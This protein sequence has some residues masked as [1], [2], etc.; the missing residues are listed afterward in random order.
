M[1]H[2]LRAPLLQAMG[3]ALLHGQAPTAAV[4]GNQPPPS[5]TSWRTRFELGPGAV[6]NFSLYGRPELDR[7]GFRISPDG[8]ISYLEA[9]NIKVAGLSLD[10][11]RLAIEKGLSTSF[12][13]P[14]VIITPQE[15]G[16]KRYTILGKVVNRGVVTLER[17]ITLVEAIAHA[18]GIE[19]GL[20]EKNTVELAD[21]DRSFISRN[22]QRLQ[23]DFRRLLHDGE[24]SRNIEV[25][26]N[27]FIYI[28]S[29]I[30]NDYY[31]LGAVASPGVQ[32]LTPDASVVSAITRRSGLTDRAWADKILVI[33]GSFDKPQTFVINMKNILAAK[34]SDF[35]L[36]P[37]DIV[38]IADR[39]WAAAEDILKGALSAFVT[40]AST[41]WINLNVDSALKP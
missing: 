16:S 17:P 33:R 18:G 29:N 27:D 21:L 39:P 38:Y 25:E 1:K 7:P 2:R 20:F 41:S 6:V 5:P 3:I 8:T 9:Q 26:P 11:A 36:Q 10:E 30:S 12:R 32:G 23:V 31:V 40:S 37:K 34:E 15:V 14:R 19:T 35:K 28:A 22:G 24:M 13:S 4:P